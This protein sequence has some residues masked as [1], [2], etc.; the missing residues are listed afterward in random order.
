MIELDRA[1]YSPCPLCEEGK[2]GP[3]WQIKARRVILDE[4][5]QTVSYRDARLE[6]FGV[7]I[8]YTP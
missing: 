5:A 7:P 8:A 4:K 2:G 3:L 1:V 6:M